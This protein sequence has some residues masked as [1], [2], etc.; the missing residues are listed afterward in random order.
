MAQKV[1]PVDPESD[2]ADDI[3]REFGDHVNMTA[4]ELERWLGTDESKA[5]GQKE[6]GESVGHDSGR[7]IVN[8]LR[9]RK[10][11]LSGVDLGHMKKVNGYVS[12]HLKQRPKKPKGELEDTRWTQSLKNWGHDPLK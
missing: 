7:R 8:I 9:T 12:R 2:E 1:N 4:S 11:D 5:V 3:R 6:G 10:G